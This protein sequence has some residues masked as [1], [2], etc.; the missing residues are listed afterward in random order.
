MGGESA[1]ETD[2]PTA[3]SAQRRLPP[4]RSCACCAS[5]QPAWAD[6][7]CPCPLPPPPHA[8]ANFPAASVAAH[9]PGGLINCDGVDAAT[10]L[11]A[12]MTLLPLDPTCPPCSVMAMMPEHKAA[13]WKTPIW[14]TY[15][16]VVCEAEG[17][18]VPFVEVE[19]FAFYEEAKKSYV[20][21]STGETAF[22]ANL[23]LKKGIIG[24]SGAGEGAA[25][26][27]GSAAKKLE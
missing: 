1:G 22:Y 25:A 5:L 6:G 23:I 17:R 10:L 8:D 15:K 11:R 16:A 18:D 9:T 12:V 21:V 26:G 13:G 2:A 19:R 27:A 20:V 4:A 14:D 3:G 7:R 24:S